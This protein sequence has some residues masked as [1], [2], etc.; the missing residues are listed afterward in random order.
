M[1]SGCSKTLHACASMCSRRCIRDQTCRLNLATGILSWSRY[2]ATVRLAIGYPASFILITRSS[3][4]RGANLSSCLMICCKHSLIALVD[5]VSPSLL[6]IPSEKKYLSEKIPNSVSTYL[7]L[8]A[9]EMV[10]IS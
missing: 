8:K 10:D 3:S 7:S 9:R 2:L 1:K 5:C 6:V 4:V